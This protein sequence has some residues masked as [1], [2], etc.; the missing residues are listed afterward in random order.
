MSETVEIPLFPLKSIVFP[1]GLLMLRIFEPRYLDMV[2]DCM[3]TNKGFG[4]CAIYEGREI[5]VAAKIHDVGT[6]VNVI[7]FEMLPDGLLGITTRGEKKFKLL[8]SHV[9][10]NQLR[11]GF[12]DYLPQEP[13][14]TI[15]GNLL[16]LVELLRRIIPEVE[17]YFGKAQM[18]YMEYDYQNAAWVGA[19]L[20]EFL[21]LELGVKQ[22]LLECQNPLERLNVLYETLHEAKAL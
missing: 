22:M 9:L 5:G 15:T 21:P 19:R 12:V 1:G 10:S 6:L 16:R 14:E 8:G 20:A 17:E 2:R 11:V 3:R 4:V 7:D 18:D 13:Q